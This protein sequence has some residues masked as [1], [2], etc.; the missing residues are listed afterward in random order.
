MNI[1]NKSDLQI[2]IKN[3]KLSFSIDRFEENFAVCEVKETNE[4]INISKELLPIA[5]KEGD[6]LKIDNSEL[7]IDYE[8]T[9]NEQKEIKNLVDGLF[10]KNK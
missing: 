6:I 5:A 2:F 1:L 3:K 8:K 4:I 10:K 9:K 7:I